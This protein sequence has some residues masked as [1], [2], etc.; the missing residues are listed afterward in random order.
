MSISN[1]KRDKI[2]NMI[3]KASEGVQQEIQKANQGK[4]ALDGIKQLQFIETKLN[5][6]EKILEQEDWRTSTK[7]KPGIARLVVDT[8]P[9][10]D[11]LGNVISQ[12]EYEFEHLK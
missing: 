4:Q 6:M 10:D 5:E 7:K 3:A 11:P 1:A 9:M 8:W 12:I 2:L